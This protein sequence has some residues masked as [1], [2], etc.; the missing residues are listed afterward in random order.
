MAGAYRKLTVLR[1]A[2]GL[3]AAAPEL[4]TG[5]FQVIVADPPWQYETGNSL[6]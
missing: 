2:K 1:Q 5:P 4:P 3:E 6:P